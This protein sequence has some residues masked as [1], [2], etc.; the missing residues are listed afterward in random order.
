LFQADAVFAGSVVA[1]LDLTRLPYY[2]RLVWRYV[3]FYPSTRYE[4]FYSHLVL[5]RVQEAWKGVADTFIIVR[6]GSVS[7]YCG[8]TFS[9]NHQYLVYGDDWQGDLW[10]G[11]CTRTVEL[12]QADEDLGYLQS[13]PSLALAPPWLPITGLGLAL[14]LIVFLIIGVLFLIIRRFQRPR[15]RLFGGDTLP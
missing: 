2:D 7:S 10:T 11:I 5:F 4:N 14:G 9:P 6:T 8:Y 3:E 12:T 1:V 13:V 15:P